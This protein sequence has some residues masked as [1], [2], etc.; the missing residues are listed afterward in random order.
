M[1]ERITTKHR[2]DTTYNNKRYKQ[3]KYKHTENSPTITT[4]IVL[5]SLYLHMSNVHMSTCPNVHIS[6]PYGST[7]PYDPMSTCPCSDILIQGHVAGMQDIVLKTLTSNVKI[8]IRKNMGNLPVFLDVFSL[9]TLCH[10]RRFVCIP[11][12]SLDHLS[13]DVLS[14]YTFCPYTLCR[15]IHFVL[16]HF[17][18]LDV[19]S[20]YVLAHYTFCLFR[21]FVRIHFVSLDVLS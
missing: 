12:V 6:S 20:V 16:L 7:C 21:R 9:Q 1:T 15:I 5:M 19:L 18:S 3:Y 11:F 14:H 2:K 13:V 17:V 10:I 8:S 4:T